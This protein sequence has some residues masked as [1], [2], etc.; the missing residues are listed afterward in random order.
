LGIW[1]SLLMTAPMGQGEMVQVK[2]TAAGVPDIIPCFQKM[3]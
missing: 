3:H 1:N 2:I